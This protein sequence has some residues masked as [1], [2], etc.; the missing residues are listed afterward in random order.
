MKLSLSLSLFLSVCVCACSCCTH[1]RMW[2]SVYACTYKVQKLRLMT[3][4]F[5]SLSTYLF[6]KHVWLGHPAWP[7]TLDPPDLASSQM[8]GFQT[9]DSSLAIFVFL[10]V[11]VLDTK[12]GA[13][14]LLSSSLLNY[15]PGLIFFSPY[16]KHYQNE[17]STIMSKLRA[18]RHSRYGL[19]HFVVVVVKQWSRH[20]V[21]IGA[22]WVVILMVMMSMIRVSMSFIVDI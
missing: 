19:L 22:M 4:V 3:S 14:G 15:T 9:C 1:A 8:L 12:S 6:M 11:C 18:Y 20:S 10:C 21:V 13:S 7:Q 17:L 5:L 2:I 16:L